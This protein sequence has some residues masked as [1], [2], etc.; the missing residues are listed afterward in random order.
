MHKTGAADTIVKAAA[1]LTLILTHIYV[2]TLHIDKT[3]IYVYVYINID[4]T[5]SF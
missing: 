2:Y 1:G 3:H 4:P 5:L